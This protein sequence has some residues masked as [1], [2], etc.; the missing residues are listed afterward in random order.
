MRIYQNSSQIQYNFTTIYFIS[1]SGSDY[2]LWRQRQLL[3][4][5]R[6]GDEIFRKVKVILTLL[7]LLLG[8]TIP[9]FPLLIKN[10]EWL[11]FNPILP[12]CSPQE[13]LFYLLDI[14]VEC[15]V[16]QCSTCYWPCS[17]RTPPT[18]WSSK[19]ASSW[20]CLFHNF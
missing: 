2:S 13:N 18:R 1:Q 19:R 8:R 6:L 20:C 12:F 15:K 3:Y 5:I 9:H 16:G 10:L 17:P 14:S 11:S 7:W 4:V